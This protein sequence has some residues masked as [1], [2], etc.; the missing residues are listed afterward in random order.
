[1]ANFS[2]RSEDNLR[3]VHPKLAAVLRAAIKDTPVDFTI[4]EGV[5]TVERQQQLYAQGRT[6][7]GP[8]VTHTDG[9]AK[10]SNHQPKADGYGYAVDLYPYVGGK[11]QVHD[12]SVPSWLRRIARHIQHHAQAHGVTVQWG[13]DWKMRDYPHFEISL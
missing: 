1:M 9:V 8:I 10:K 13:G 12:E 3:G 6:T 7:A 11:V 2:K 5:R 4:T